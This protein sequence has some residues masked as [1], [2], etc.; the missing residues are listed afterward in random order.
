MG[1]ID[2]S[3]SRIINIFLSL[4]LREVNKTQRRNIY[5]SLS[6]HVYI[7]ITRVSCISFHTNINFS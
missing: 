4:F 2:P 6:R 1:R 7:Y 3:L 5:L